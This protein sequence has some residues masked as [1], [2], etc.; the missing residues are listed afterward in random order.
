[1]ADTIT[2]RKEESKEAKSPSKR[3][4]TTAQSAL[5]EVAQKLEGNYDNG[6][7]MKDLQTRKLANTRTSINFGNEKVSCCFFS[8]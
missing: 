8:S 1:M 4:A 5:A 2:Y 7:R 3:W 6:K